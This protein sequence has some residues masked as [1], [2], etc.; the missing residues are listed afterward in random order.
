MSKCK[1]SGNNIHKITNTN[2]K[3]LDKNFE[4]VA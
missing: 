3:E 2:D 1:R 4:P